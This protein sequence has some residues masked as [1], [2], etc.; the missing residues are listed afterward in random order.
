[1][2]FTLLLDDVNG[3]ND[4]AIWSIYYHLYLDDRSLTLLQTQSKKLHDL[5][6]SIDS[7]RDSRYGKLIR[8]GDTVTLK[9]IREVWGSYATSDLTEDE[10]LAYEKR[11]K[12]GIQKAVDARNRLMG[13]ALVI[14]GYRSAAPVGAQSLLDLPHLF[15]HFWDHG[16]TDKDPSTLSK[17]KHSN[18]M[19]SSLVTDTFTLHYGT[20]P[21]LGFHLATAYVSLSPD[22]PLY[23]QTPLGHLQKLVAAARIQFQAWAVSFRSKA[24]QNM[25]IRFF[26]GDALALSHTLQHRRATGTDDLAHWYRT[27]YHLESLILDGSDYNN[28][29]KAPLLFNVID[30]SNLSDHLGSIN[31]LVATS[32]LLANSISA[33]LY[34]E[35]LVKV[36]DDHKD[37]IDTLLCGHFPTVSTLLGLFPV[38][39]WT[40]AT[41]I[42][43]VDDGIVDSMPNFTRAKGNSQG[44][45]R[46][47]L[48]WK[49]PIVSLGEMIQ[50]VAKLCVSERDLAKLL[51]QV[52]RGMFQNEDFRKLFSKISLLTVQTSSCPHYHRGSFASFL[53][54]VKGRVKADWTKVMDILLPLVENDPTILMGRNYIQELYLQLHLLNLCT[55]ATL[56]PSFNKTSPVLGSC[57]L[58]AWKDIPG[59]ICINLKVPRERIGVFTSLPLGKLGTPNVHCILQ[60]SKTSSSRPWQNIF[61]AVQL[62]FGT[63]TT[64]NSRNRDDF[65][66]NVAEDES[67]WTGRSS[68]LVSFYAPA[69]VALLEPRTT[70]VAFGVQSTPLSTQTFMK[71]LGAEMNVYETTLV[72]QDK[73]YIT[74]YLPN[75]SGYT[76]ICGFR[77]DYLGEKESPISAFRTTMIANLDQETVRIVSFTGRVDFLT[78]E[79]KSNLRTQYPVETLQLSACAIAILIGKNRRKYLLHFPTP[80]QNSRAKI[81]IARRSSYVEVVAPIAFPMDENY[82]LP[83]FMYSSI[84]AGKN[85]PVIWNMPY[86][87]LDCLPVLNVGK[88]MSLE[89]LV[90]HASLQLSARERKLRDAST[91]ITHKVSHNDVRVGFKDG[92]FSMFMH[93]S[94]LQGRKAYIFGINNP[95]GGGIHILIFV[96]CLRLDI[97]NHTVILDSAVLPLTDRLMPRLQQFLG[98]LSGMEFCNIVVDD[99]ELKLWKELLP[100]FVERCR[101]WVHRPSCEY[102][103]KAQIPLSTENGEPVLCSCGNGTLPP[104]FVSGI[105][106]WHVASKFAVRAALSPSFSV[107]FVEPTFDI[108]RIKRELESHVDGCQNCRKENSDENAKLLTCSRCHIAKYCSIECQRADWK[109]HKKVC[110][111]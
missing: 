86:L 78:E 35:F 64:S 32:P 16:V 61:A 104:G 25:T 90:T 77:D 75:Q 62:T 33:T 106:E 96:S 98:P 49:R 71:A 108:E 34:T 52:Y 92:L 91:S 105:P 22:S 28:T 89:W 103:A 48:V 37:W 54:L 84:Q 27:P 101:N 74:K 38:E 30:T 21:I 66:V 31:I 41:A 36:A 26:V 111:K 23:R 99:D 12:A 76:S 83:H 50:P 109:G 14:T 94:G 10:N 46:S 95:N 85:Y 65:C 42:S 93:F 87:K 15:Q 102:V 53:R 79:T 47:R 19:F 107:P 68:L 51:H 44:Q 59:V 69:W 20:D 55:M 45:M 4:T 100:C 29:G 13:P 18:P 57:G 8:F 56:Q 88:N 5:S 58:E 97:A 70:T 82:R 110:G 63:I 39:Y 11:F 80:V 6:G 9:R 43:S 73:V 40:N 1:M 81:R 2:L 60:S 72:D 17:A 24:S 7:W 3:L 67:G